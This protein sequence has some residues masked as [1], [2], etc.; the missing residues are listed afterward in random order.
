MKKNFKY[1]M[2]GAIALT[3][4]TGFTACSDNS[5]S[6]EAVNNSNYNAK[7]G[8]VLVDFALNLS[9]NSQDT[10][11]PA[12]TVQ[13]GTAFR[14]I[15]NA[16]LYTYKTAT[17]G[18]YITTDA[19]ACDKVF[20]LNL[21]LDA[22]ALNLSGEPKSRR[23]LE[24]SLPTGTNTLMFWGRAKK[25]S[26][27]T[28]YN[29][30]SN[31]GKIT[32]SPN[33]NLAQASFKLAPC[34]NADEK[35]KL[36][37][38]EQLIAAVLNKIVQAE[39]DITNLT[40]GGQ[41]IA[42]KKMK[43]SD[44]VDFTST[45]VNPGT[46]SEKVVVTLTPKEYDPSTY[47]SADAEHAPMSPLGL[48]LANLFV[49]LNTFS[50]SELRNGEGRMVEWIVKDIYNI[51]GEVRNATAVTIEEKAAQSVAA[52]IHTIIS[53][54]FDVT[55]TSTNV[56][57][58]CKWKE[59]STDVL[60]SAG[61]ASADY[62]ALISDSKSLSDFPDQI[63][64]LP[65]GATILQYKAKDG[66]NV[67]NE[68]AYV[69]QVPT[70]AMGNGN[71]FDP[72]NYMYPAELCYFGNSPIRVSN[73]THE[74][75]SYPDGATVWSTDA[76]WSSDWKAGAGQGH[77]LSSTRSVA[78]KDNINYGT[79]M[80]V[81]TVQYKTGVTTLKDNNSGLHAGEADNE[82]TVTDGIL[83][84][85]GV[86]VGGQ[87]Q[88]VGWNYLPK[89]D[90]PFVCM[91]YDD[92]L[93]STAVPTPTGKQNYT[94]V[95]DNWNQASKGAK[96]NIVYVALQFKNNTGKDFW[97]QNNVIRSGSTF[98]IIGALDP[99]TQPTT[100]TWA[101]ATDYETD[102][103]KG[104][105]WPT[106]YALPPYDATNGTTIKERRIFIQ[107]YK[108]TAN[109]VINQNSLKYALVSVP[110]LRSSQITLGLSVDLTWEQGLNFENVVVGG[111]E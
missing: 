21:L 55:S 41:T 44:Y 57:S 24:M 29:A 81:T 53:Y 22:D 45:T 98:Y 7:T 94:L 17:D 59:I 82:I 25:G 20:D 9:T 38:Y 103:S 102:K 34:T 15:Q 69:D 65:P 56:A 95:W 62:T 85:T 35:V 107:D 43:W 39:V 75:S 60:T 2:L 74:V 99:D 27:T 101:S 93:P 78:M 67:K 42:S 4:A 48:K 13:E 14:G 91:V 33:K 86:L 96:Q 5:V 68:Y 66:E 46:A 88:E 52:R 90:N 8:E 83:Q 19:T 80:L 58:A 11:M 71:A 61:L 76:S 18:S 97:G 100:G 79:S 10:R 1:A 110:D 64:R 106:A 50:D 105:T 77:V 49:T 37:K 108:T 30:D 16:M 87:A 104:I 70:Y 3:G 63:F 109:F 51:M 72:N 36:Q 89:G 6:E 73:D 28:S 26:T 47:N 54:F 84:L 12:T 32:F 40:F 92:Q 31:E 111:G 23:V